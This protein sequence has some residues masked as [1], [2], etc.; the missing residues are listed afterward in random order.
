MSNNEQPKNS[1]TKRVLAWIGIVLVV[2][3]FTATMLL[4]LLPVPN[5]DRLFPFFIFGCIIIPILIWVIIWIVG[6][7]TGKRTVASFRSEETQKMM[8]EADE[9]RYREIVKA[10]EGEQSEDP[11]TEDSSEE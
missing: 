5:K 4:A 8:D 10:T 11:A 1:K 3:W 6:L 7:L 2:L 9:I